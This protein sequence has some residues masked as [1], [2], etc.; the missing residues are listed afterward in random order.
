MKKVILLLMAVLL[1]AMVGCRGKV[2]RKMK[3]EYAGPWYGTVSTDNGSTSASVDGTGTVENDYGDVPEIS[4]AIGKYD[5]GTGIN[6]TV[7]LIESYESG[8]LSGASSEVK[9]EMSTTAAF[10]V[11]SIGYA[12]DSATPTPTP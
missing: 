5:Q 1:I 4:A 12:F 3:V 11:V 8:F 9:K 6:L 7:Q 2:H 10:G